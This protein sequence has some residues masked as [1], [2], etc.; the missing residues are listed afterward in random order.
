MRKSQ[1][2]PTRKADWRSV[3]TL[4]LGLPILVLLL[5][6]LYF[7]PVE[8][9]ALPVAIIATGEYPPFSGEQLKDNGIAAAIVSRAM[10]EIG[11]ESELKFMPW[12]LATQSTEE[13][14]TNQGV[15]AAFPYVKSPERER[16]FYFSDPILTVE[17]SIFYNPAK[18]P[19]ITE[20][21]ALADLKDYRLLPIAGYRYLDPV[22]QLPKLN[23]AAENNLDAFEQLLNDPQTQLVAEATAVGNQI[24]ADSF[25]R[26][27]QQIKSLPAFTSPL[28]LIASKRNPYSRSLILE[29]N[30][31]LAAID[32]DQRQEIA[33]AVLTQINEQ[34]QVL[35]NAF[36]G[37]GYLKGY[38]R[39]AEQPVLLPQGTR[40]LV[41]QW[42]ESYLNAV[43]EPSAEA[44][45][46]WARVKILNGPL[47]QEIL[48]VD[49]RA[50]A[51]P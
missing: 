28:Y 38:F 12:P 20:Q 5:L 13:S 30:Q 2:T 10:K 49:G 41:E 25:P 15:R 6:F 33:S 50:V 14:G 34:N 42:P 4:A 31:A 22:E 16:E 1:L 47:R 46:T 45:A 27:R 9:T 8:R 19:K 39:P 40:A 43:G 37:S 21:T 48:Y 11:Y 23:R 51:L 32:E 44:I 36:D 17:T 3:T 7:R 35:L 24:L 26:Q 18:T 29:F